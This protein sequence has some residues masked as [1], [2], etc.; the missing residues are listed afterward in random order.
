MR[1]G[2]QKSKKIAPGEIFWLHVHVYIKINNIIVW[3]LI[4]IIPG[5]R[6][7]ETEPTGGTTPDTTA[8]INL[9]ATTG[10]TDTTDS[11][12]NNVTTKVNSR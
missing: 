7:E 9:P 5:E 11:S 2:G 3:Y 10:D 1:A 4:C 8:N 12:Q 6:C